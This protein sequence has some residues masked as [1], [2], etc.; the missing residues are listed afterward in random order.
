MHVNIHVYLNIFIIYF[1]NKYHIFYVFI[2]LLPKFTSQKR[3][4]L[5]STV[6][7]TYLYMY[8]YIY[9]YIYIYVYIHIYWFKYI[10][11]YLN[12]CINIYIKIFIYITNIYITE[13]RETF[14][15]CGDARCRRWILL[16]IHICVMTVLIYEPSHPL[17]LTL[18]FNPS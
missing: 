3:K 7:V 13:K 9:I 2:N 15:Y 4:R 17:I 10:Y 14:F 11:T 18:S 8:I 5:S 6:A 12:I 16:S 1:T